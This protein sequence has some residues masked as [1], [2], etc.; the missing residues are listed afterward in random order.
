MDDVS[1]IP[2]PKHP[3]QAIQDFAIDYSQRY[4]ARPALVKAGRVRNLSAH[5]IGHAAQHQSQRRWGRLMAGVSD[6][7]RPAKSCPLPDAQISRA[8]TGARKPLVSRH[9]TCQQPCPSIVSHL[10]RRQSARSHLGKFE[11]FSCAMNLEELTASAKSSPSK[12]QKIATQ[13]I[14][15]L[16]PAAA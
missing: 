6:F 3:F 10:C 5:V 15:V 4:R 8:P 14:L 9:S 16:N 7:G 12:Y 11:P 13:A 1:K 2:F